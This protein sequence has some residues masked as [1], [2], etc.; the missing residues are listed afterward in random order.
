DRER[1]INL[2]LD[3]QGG[4]H[5]VL[6]FDSQEIEPERRQEFLDSGYR[7]ADIQYLIQ[8]QV[9]QQISR[10]V[11]DFEAKEPIIQTLG[12]NQV[13]IQLPGEKDIQRAKNLITKTALLNFHIVDGPDET[14]KLFAT[15]KDAY[16]DEFVPF[17]NRPL[18]GEPFTV[19]VEHYNRV[20]EVLQKAQEKGLIPEDKVILFSQ[21]P[22]AY[23]KQLYQLYVLDKK[24]I[25]SGEGLTSA[26][27]IPDRD[28]PP[29]WMT[30]FQFNNDAGQRF[31]LATEANINRAMAIVLDN[32]VVSAPTIR[33]RIDTNGQITGSFEDLEARDLSIALNSG[34]MVVPVHEELSMVVG[35]SL[36]AD[37]VSKGVLSS[38]VGVAVVGVFMII[39]YLW[40]GLIAV[41]CLILNGLFIV[42]A[43]AY[44]NMT[45]TL[46]GIAGLILTVGMAVDSNVL[47]FE[48]MREE[49][50]LGHTLLSS[51]ENGFNRVAVTILDANITTL[52]AAAVLF[53]FGTG[54]IEGFAVTLTIGILGTV[55]TALVVCRAMIDFVVA[56]KWVTKFTMLH[57]LPREPRV[58]WMK[59]A[60]PASTTSLIIIIAGMVFFG[61]RGKEMFGVDFSEGTTIQL[62]LGAD[63]H[64]PV[65]DLR[66]ALGKADFDSPIVQE[67]EEGVDQDINKFLIRVSDINPEAAAPAS[68]AAS[69]ETAAQPAEAAPAPAETAPVTPEAAPAPA[70]PAPVTPEA[71]PAEPVSAPADGEAAPPEPATEQPAASAEAEE[72]APPATAAAPVTPPA[73]AGAVETV[74]ERIQK[75][76]APLTR[77]GS[78]ASVRIL[79][80]QTV[81]PAVGAQLRMDALK[82]VF[83]SFFFII[84]YLAIRFELKFAAGAI[85][86]V[87]HDVLI[88]VAFFA[89]FGFEIDM[90]VIAA[91][92]T[93]IGYS[94][95]DTIVIFDRVREDLRLYRGKGYKFSQILNMAVNVTMART[96]LTSL[97][98]FFV[99]VVLLIFGGDAL[100]GFS[101]ALTIGVIAG[102]YSTIFIASPVAYVWQQYQIRHAL[103]EEAKSL[104]ETRRKKKSSGVKPKGGAKGTPA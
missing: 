34:S 7:E 2:G 13:Q 64:V 84:I 99:V 24:P 96:L 14:V 104:D 54:P 63:Q 9:L 83:A 93:L 75:A 47:I 58:N 46:P 72:P 102:T 81:G 100:R 50:K 65:E 31:G 87:F 27:A 45:L 28:N 16:P 30:P 74:G 61:V 26:A 82:A 52:I 69:A 10:R 78:P 4:V 44:F 76:L 1:V 88:T 21:P 101:I 23:Q 5:M 42:A 41:I 94:L 56:R 73:T 79:Q 92:L 85:V 12:R 67:L 6:G 68:A 18:P 51:I 57:I 89:F 98:V 48:R 40:A 17:I 91:I 22:K 62:S 60:L 95:N 36:G 38:L 37:A 43:M 59:Y 71:A 49:L 103:A 35:A 90:N 8:Q 19:A 25:A 80:E 29:Y 11:N 32:V 97:T 86:A 55:F 33:D 39:Y 20:K 15:I 77:D 66:V 3:L 53:Q 70:E